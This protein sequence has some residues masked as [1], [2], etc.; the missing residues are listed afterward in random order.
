MIGRLIEK[1]DI[2]LTEERLSLFGRSVWQ[3]DPGRAIFYQNGALYL[4]RGQHVV[5]FDEN[6][7]E[8]SFLCFTDP[9][10][11][12]ECDPQELKSSL[13]NEAKAYLQ[14]FR[15]GDCLKKRWVGHPW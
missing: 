2:G 7:N 12:R 1:Q 6:R 5:R 11:A 8:S 4:V 13:E 3:D 15:N 14:Y 10:L 9:N